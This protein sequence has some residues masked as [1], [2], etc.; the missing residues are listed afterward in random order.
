MKKI[1]ILVFILLVLGLLL[2][3]GISFAQEG[4]VK[5][6]SVPKTVAIISEY[7]IMG[8]PQFAFGT[9]C[10]AT[11]DGYIVTNAHVVRNADRITVY[12]SELNEYGARI[13][14]LHSECD[15][16]LIKILPADPLEY[17]D[18]ETWVA[19]PNQVFLM[20]EVYAIGHP[21]GSIFTITRG[22]IS[23]KLEGQDGVR[24]FQTDASLN[25]G[26]SGGALVN[27]WGQ[28]IAINVSAIPAFFAENMGY[29]IAVGSF[30]EEI[31]MMIEEDMARLEVF[32]NIREYVNS[33]WTRYYNQTYYGN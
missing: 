6:N 23:N 9:G 5:W 21:Y 33:K 7:E 12:D 8:V 27:R 19:N 31:R 2:N 13:V 22:T 4:P 15:I 26:N 20:D 3:T 16:A 10:I 29:A 30:V 32:E 28:L 25:P 14:G 1:L 11:A 17:F 18:E 24:Y